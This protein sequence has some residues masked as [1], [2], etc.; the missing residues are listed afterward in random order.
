VQPSNTTI[1][2]ARTGR[3][4]NDQEIPAVIQ[5]FPDIAKISI[6]HSEEILPETAG[7]LMSKAYE[8][9]LSQRL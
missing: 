7:A 5:S 2:E 6:H 8:L 9:A 1:A 3:V 4:R